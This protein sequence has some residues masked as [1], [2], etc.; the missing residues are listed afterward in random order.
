M[1]TNIKKILKMAVLLISSLLIGTVSASIY[2]SLSISGTLTTSVTVCFDQGNDWPSGSTMGTGNTS[3][4][5][6]LKAYPNTTL[7]YEK[8]VNVSNTQSGTP[9]VR[10]RH[11]SITNGTADV[12]N[13]TFLKIVLLDD[14]GTQKGY[15]NYTVSGNYFILSESTTYQQMDANE[16]W[17]IRIE[18][19]AEADATA[20]IN[21][22]LQIAV[23]VQE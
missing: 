7:T 1:K 2:Y 13:F 20:G 15:L 8:A 19:K 9:L 4:T 6:S 11:I 14:T 21:V 17:T 16:E 22:N 10:L 18:T 12:A 3:V 23:D 5:L